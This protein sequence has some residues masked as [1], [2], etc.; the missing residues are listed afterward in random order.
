[1]PI[2]ARKDDRSMIH[3]LFEAYRL[4]QEE[5]TGTT[6][7]HAEK[8]STADRTDFMKP[9]RTLVVVTAATATDDATAIVLAND[10]KA[11]V[12]KHFGDDQAHDA[13]TSAAI[14]IADATDLA[15]AITLANDLKA[16]YNTHRTASTVHHNND[17]TNDVTNANATDSATLQTLINEIRGDVIA[18]MASAP[19]GPQVKLVDA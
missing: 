17:T 8:T 13:A 19:S 10:I 7:F 3:A 1:M 18:H 12:D 6:L 11:T 2:E 9:T 14:T 16:K 5:E 4:K 15:T